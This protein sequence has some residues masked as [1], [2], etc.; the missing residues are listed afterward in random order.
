MSHTSSSKIHKYDAFLSFRGE[1]TRRT[2]VSHL[3]NALIQR[4]IDV[5]KDDERL[6]TGKSI[7]DE[8]PKAIEESKFAIVIFSE[9]YASSTWCL[10]EL[11]HIIKCRKELGQIVIPIFYNVSPSDVSHQNPP[12]NK[13][14]SEH[15]KNYK[16]DMEKIQRWR[17]AFA[18]SGKIS[19]YHLQNYKDEADCIKKV[20]YKLMSL[21][22]IEYH[23][24]D[25]N[26]D[27]VC[28]GGTRGMGA[29]SPILIDGGKMSYSL[30]KKTGK[31]CFMVAARGLEIEWGGTAEYWEWISH[32]D[33]RFS[34]VAK[35]KR[36]CWLD[37]RGKIE[38][39]RL[40]KR[41][42]YVAYLVFKLEN[43]FHGLE[44][45][46]A[47]VRFVDS[48]SVKEAERRASVVHFSGQ[49]PRETLPFKRGDGWME[50]KMGDFFNDAGEDGDVDARLMET[51]HLEAKGGLIVQVVEFRPE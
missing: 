40:S 9:S 49:G 39:R 46:N 23:E 16:D 8:L 13:F 20:V 1:D 21:L 24:D 2:F 11:A 34:E 14:F 31:K 48:M 29:K 36:V 15:E 25:N 30:D 4:R 42:K 26:D 18:V 51:E 41:T 22:H 38:T 33:S 5:F 44:T 28:S 37:I 17:D 6:E 43:K 19:G 32:P 47:V 45:V 12:F 3:Y 10:D 27:D 7:H 35:L 50:L